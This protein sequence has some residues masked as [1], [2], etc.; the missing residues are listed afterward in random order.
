MQQRPDT[1]EELLKLVGS[2]SR[3]ACLIALIL[4]VVAF[5]INSR[6]AIVPAVWLGASFFVLMTVRQQ[7]VQTSTAV[8]VF[9]L[10]TICA[11]VGLVVFS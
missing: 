3:L 9:G 6:K 7:N 2:L 5:S 4:I 1:P 10:V 11:F 8:G